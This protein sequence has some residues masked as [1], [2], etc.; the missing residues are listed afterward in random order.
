[1]S[2]RLDRFLALPQLSDLAQLLEKA[3]G[4]DYIIFDFLAESV[5][6]GMGRGMADG[7]GSGFAADF[8]DGYILPHLQKLLD[9]RIRIV[10]L[11][12]L[13]WARSGDKG[14]AQLLLDFPVPVC[15]G[16]QRQS[17]W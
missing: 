9:R 10:P 17:G 7:T 8:V 3:D 4:L 1:M 12:R 6:G 5:M 11:I 15:A 16:L 2:R 14:M 13:A